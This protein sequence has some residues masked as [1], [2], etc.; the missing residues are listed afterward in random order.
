MHTAAEKLSCVTR[1][2]IVYA[3]E[4]LVLLLLDVPSALAQ[5]GSGMRVVAIFRQNG[6]SRAHVT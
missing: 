2:T 3:D 1:R 5:P 6:L 4:P